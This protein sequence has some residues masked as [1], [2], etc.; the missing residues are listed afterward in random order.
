MAWLSS[1]NNVCRLHSR[2]WHSYIVNFEK[3]DRTRGDPGRQHGRRT[4]VIRW[5]GKVVH[6]GRRSSHRLQRFV[7]FL[8][9]KMIAYPVQLIASFCW[10]YMYGQMIWSA[11]GGFIKLIIHFELECIIYKVKD[12]VIKWTKVVYWKCSRVISVHGGSRF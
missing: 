2:E 1:W 8:L 9:Y 4:D 12:K 10:T 7:A 6:T 5:Q 3:E 11:S